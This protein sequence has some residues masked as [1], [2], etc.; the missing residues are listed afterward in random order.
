MRPAQSNN[1][2]NKYAGAQSLIFY[3]EPLDDGIFCARQVNELF[4]MM[5]DSL[6][7]KKINK[8]P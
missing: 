3:N 8:F 7:N 4:S 1:C 2:D 6:P 5:K